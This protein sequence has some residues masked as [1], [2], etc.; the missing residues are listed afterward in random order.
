MKE[1]HKN[2]N[3]GSADH[4]LDAITCLLDAIHGGKERK[5]GRQWRRN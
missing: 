4:L 5:E 3:H 1:N 2:I